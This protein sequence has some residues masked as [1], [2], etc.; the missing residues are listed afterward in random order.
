[1]FGK[2]RT[3]IGLKFSSCKALQISSKARLVQGYSLTSFRFLEGVHAIFSL[4]IGH[5]L[6][7]WWIAWVKDIGQEETRRAEEHLFEHIF[8]RRRRVLKK[9][10]YRD[11]RWMGEESLPNLEII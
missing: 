5:I 3:H 1:L 7:Q 2:E 10:Y 8:A 11:V 4:A 9:E 6:T